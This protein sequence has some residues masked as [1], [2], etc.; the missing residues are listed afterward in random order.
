MLPAREEELEELRKQVA[1]RVNVLLLVKLLHTNLI[2]YS[3]K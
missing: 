1:I 2:E 3:I